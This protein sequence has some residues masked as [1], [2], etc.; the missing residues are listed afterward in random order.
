MS[1]F[2]KDIRD[3][4]KKL[5]NF[6]SS[7][8]RII[9]GGGVVAL[10]RWDTE[11]ALLRIQQLKI[12]VQPYSKSCAFMLEDIQSKLFV[13]NPDGS[14]GINPFRFGKLEAVLLYL[15]SS[16]FVCD[17]AKYIDTPWEDINHSIK[18]LLTDSANASDRLSYNQIGVLGREIY[19]ML[20]KK[21]YKPEMNNREDGKKISEADAKG[22]ISSYI[23]Y[24]LKGTS[25]KELKDYADSAIKL[26]EHV[27]HSKSETKTD[28]DSLVTSVIALAA[29]INIIYKNNAK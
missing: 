13:P 17:F 7:L 6:Y 21:V 15:E 24:V 12:K 16:D 18:K 10:N 4:V 20:G 11:A 22:M 14:T 23:E 29:V 5:Q 19:I 28:M 1:L 27:T 8:A 3:N 26:A 25:S 9:N 2:M